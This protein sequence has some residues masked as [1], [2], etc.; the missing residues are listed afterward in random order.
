MSSPPSS[1]PLS[2]PKT[3]EP[4]DVR[5]RPVS[6]RTAKGLGAPSAGS[7]VKSSPEASSSPA[8]AS[9]RPSFASAR[10]AMSRPTAYAAE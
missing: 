7:T 2:A 4:V 9:A 6:S 1:A 10:R 5:L 3:R 8:Y